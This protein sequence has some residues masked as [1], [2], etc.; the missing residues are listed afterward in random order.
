MVARLVVEGLTIGR[1]DPESLD[2][3]E[4]HAD[5]DLLGRENFILAIAPE[6][7]TVRVQRVELV[8]L[9]SSA[10]AKNDSGGSR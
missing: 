9:K 1:E 5:L 10:Q 8:R 7:L 2:W 6:Q 4:A 3:K